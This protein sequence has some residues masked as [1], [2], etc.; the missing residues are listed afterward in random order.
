MFG[1]QL[2]TRWARTAAVGLL[3]VLVGA[4]VFG[5]PALASTTHP[6]GHSRHARSA[7]VTGTT[8]SSSAD[9]QAA[10]SRVQAAATA[11]LQGLVNDGT[12][13]Q[14]QA[15]VIDAQIDAGTVDDQQL[16]A[17]GVITASQMSAVDNA[18][19][20]VKRSFAGSP[21]SGGNGNIAS[22]GGKTQ[23]SSADNQAA[24]ARLQAA[25]RAALQGLV[26]A[27]TINQHQADVIESAVESGSVDPNQLV[28]SG[29]LTASQ[30]QAVN[31]ALV[32][33]KQSFAA[34]SGS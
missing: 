24:G 8:K 31:S 33:V 2:R 7:T 26:T 13:S 16:V 20:Q 5:L 18:L 3:G 6:N 34:G 1:K 22:P 19:I 14:H 11:A 9:T 15:D 27:G 32:Q 29:V 25:A 23:S 21:E 4:C 12:I 30:M 10:D 28:S 17:S